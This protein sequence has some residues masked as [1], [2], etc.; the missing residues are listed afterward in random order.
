MHVDPR[1]VYG[2]TP[3]STVTKYTLRGTGASTPQYGQYCSRG[4]W[5]TLLGHRT[6]TRRGRRPRPR[7]SARM[8]AA[9]LWLAASQAVLLSGAGAA[10]SPPRQSELQQRVFASHARNATAASPLATAKVL[11]AFG[12]PEFQAALRRCCPRV[13]GLSPQQLLSEFRAQM[14]VTEVI[15]NFH[16]VVNETSG[17][18]VRPNSADVTLAML[19]NA[20]FLYNMWELAPL[21]LTNDK[22]IEGWIGMS[23]K[24]ENG[25]LRFPP[26]SAV[27]APS[28]RPFPFGGWPKDV[29]EASQRPVYAATNQWFSDA[30]WP[31]YGSVGVVF[32]ES[33]KNMTLV[34]PFDTG[35]WESGCNESSA[36]CRAHT[37]EASCNAADCSWG[38]WDGGGDPGG[39]GGGAHVHCFKPIS[40]T[41]Q[42][43]PHER[44]DCRV[45]SPMVGTDALGTL[46]PPAFD[47]LILPSV[48]WYNST[49]N[50]VTGGDWRKNLQQLAARMFS[51]WEAP[52]TDITLRLQYH[53]WEAHVIGAP[54]FPDS[55]K[56]VIGAF[57]DMF[58]TATGRLL[59]QW[60]AKHSWALVWSL[61]SNL[62]GDDMNFYGALNQTEF[63]GNRRL[64]DPHVLPRTTISQN[65]SIPNGFTSRF[66]A[67]WQATTAARARSPAG[68]RLSPTYY[69]QA[70]ELLAKGAAAM[71]VQPLRPQ[72]CASAAQC[73]GTN[74][75]GQCVCY[76][77]A[78]DDIVVPALI[79]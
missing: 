26:F 68:T 31:W 41:I 35:L 2:T 46:D 29:E 71:D 4:R 79:K 56:F 3:G 22:Y 5:L 45:W 54:L 11:A 48:Q 28:G 58:G 6:R 55:V 18:D 72:T 65:L 50:M 34:A 38:D 47:H 23:A 64:L 37:T 74:A 10:F 51:P 7:G 20:S 76:V 67:A 1:Y 40:Q 57:P 42:S 60:A 16:P 24:M 66:E 8:M 17:R 73:I 43:P 27:D 59:Q 13:A 75:A 39:G 9:V 77:D 12:S 25:L 78:D 14:E 44:I 52:A 36:W 30:G 62:P 32:A 53:Y 33:L 61:G 21:N 70:F 15:H 63:P 49:G 19:L 69:A